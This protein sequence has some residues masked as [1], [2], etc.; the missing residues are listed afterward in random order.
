MIV[1]LNQRLANQ[2]TTIGQLEQKQ[3]S[4]NQLIDR[5]TSSNATTVAMPSAPPGRIGGYNH[6]LPRSVI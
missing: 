3:L 6:K 2:S 5:L 4:S 1:D